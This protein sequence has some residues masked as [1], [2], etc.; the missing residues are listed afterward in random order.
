MILI[1]RNCSRLR[2]VLTLKWVSRIGTAIFFVLAI[3]FAYSP[4][5]YPYLG[6]RS[7][8]RQSISLLGISTY[9]VVY[10]QLRTV[11]YI[12][13]L[14]FGLLLIAAFLKSAKDGEGAKGIAA[15]NCAWLGFVLQ[16][17]IV[18]SLQWTPVFV[19]INLN[20]TLLVLFA[21]TLILLAT[22]LLFLTNYGWARRFGYLVSWGF[23][24]C[25]LVGLIM[26]M[27]YFVL[28]SDPFPTLMMVMA[29]TSVASIHYLGKLDLKN[30][31]EKNGINDGKR[32]SR[33]LKRFFTS[34]KI[35]A[36]ILAS[37]LILDSMA[38][39]QPDNHWMS[40]GSATKDFYCGVT[41]GGNTTTEAK[42][43]I[44]RVKNFTNLFVV[45]SG[46]VSKNEAVLNEICNYAVSSGLHIIVYFG[47]FDQYWQAR[48]LDT[49][50]Q[51]WG[52][53]FLGVYSFDEPGGLQLDI[54]GGRGAKPSNYSVAAANY[55]SGFRSFSRYMQML[56]MRYIKAFTS[57]YALY[58][59]DYKAGY[60]VL[61]AE[62]GWNYSRQL[63]V[64]LCRGA[65][66]VQNKDWGVM[67]TWTYT[68]PPYIESGEDLYKD[69][70]LAYENGA[71]YI[72]VFDY[73]YV[74]NSTYG[75]LKEEHLEALRKFWNYMNYNPQTSD[76]LSDRVAYVL[77]KDYGYGFRGPNDT[78]WGFWKAD[79]FSKEICTNLSNLIDQYKSKLDVIYDDGIEPNNTFVYNEFVFWNG[80]VT[81]KPIG[82]CVFLK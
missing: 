5:V 3:F 18:L 15:I 58:W 77:P 27:R 6:Y 44:D 12:C 1:V 9:S 59:F 20:S 42:L 24:F 54:M 30:S 69:M 37:V 23:L 60:D 29:I 48:W 51:R 53:K 7:F 71:K 36:I 79:T 52:E 67:V 82:T 66:T 11:V 57:D 21:V 4:F 22:S 17:S 81:V 70:I 40:N 74:S 45:D 76:S 63:N 25:N 19:W 14:G 28:F 34:S 78:I 41:F 2:S 46:P 55:I 32:F 26:M 38:F 13:S 75:I 49:A 33:E 56:K 64:A 61:F 31:S 50:R 39:V 65:A 72:L 35:L 8:F 43:L 62:F 10:S 47:L 73:P 80:T 16:A 68:D